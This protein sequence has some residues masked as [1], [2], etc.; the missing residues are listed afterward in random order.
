M[1]LMELGTW[2]FICKYLPALFKL[3]FQMSVQYY[4]L[5]FQSLSLCCKF[6]I[7]FIWQK[8]SCAFQAETLCQHCTL[9]QVFASF[10][11][12]QYLIIIHKFTP[13]SVEIVIFLT[14]RDFFYTKQ[15]YFQA[16]TRLRLSVLLSV[17]QE[18][19]CKHQ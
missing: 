2:H 18:E 11:F 4:T 17:L 3:L 12:S 8:T 7:S 9:L 1:S 5:S 19:T 14:F 15:Q 6:A 13:I 10:T 16:G